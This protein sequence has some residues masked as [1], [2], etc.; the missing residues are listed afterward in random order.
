LLAMTPLTRAAGGA[1]VVIGVVAFVGSGADS[2]TAL[3]P[4]ALGA[5]LLVLA[6]LADRQP[7]RHATWAHAALGVALVGLLGS[8]SRLGD[9]P[10][11]VAGNDVELPWATGAN[12]AVTVV[13]LAYL[14]AGFR[15]F[16]AARAAR[17]GATAP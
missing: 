17:E 4:A 2:V 3:I 5:V 12:A 9:L 1:L 6:L 10:D 15:S 13:L 7:A 11:L 8:A 14:V 16:R